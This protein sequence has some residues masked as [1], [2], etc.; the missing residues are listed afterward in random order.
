[1]KTD[2]KCH[3]CKADLTDAEAVPQSNYSLVFCPK[4]GTVNERED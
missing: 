4:C 3:R 1:M 2:N